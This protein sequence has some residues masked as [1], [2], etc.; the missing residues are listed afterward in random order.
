MP[1]AGLTGISIHLILQ[2]FLLMHKTLGEKTMC[3]MFIITIIHLKKY[4]NKNQFA[5]SSSILA[6]F[7]TD[8]ITGS[9]W[10]WKPRPF[11]LQ[12]AVHAL[13]LKTRWIEQVQTIFTVTSLIVTIRLSAVTWLRVGVIHSV[14]V[15]LEKFNRFCFLLPVAT[16]GKGVLADL[17][18]IL[19]H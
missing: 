3:Y 9:N 17:E 5:K 10:H 1:P 7:G 18:R 2:F 4:D 16:H 11:K 6:C 14:S 13:T 15:Q 8:K 12:M 19:A